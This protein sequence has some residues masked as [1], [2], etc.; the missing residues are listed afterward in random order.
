MSETKTIPCHE[1]TVLE[2]VAYYAAN[3]LQAQGYET[4]VQVMSPSMSVLIVKKDR[5][6]FKNLL[7]LGVETRA[8]LTLVNPVTI[9]AVYDSEWTNK[10][11]ALAVGWICC[12][13]PFIT[14][15]VGAVAQSELPNK[16]TT[17]I[18]A[19]ISQT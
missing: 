16:I 1:N 5:D 7:G 2:N 3:Y 13:I 19:G 6:G 14:G 17:S 9:S 8:T 15:L 11:I 4:G 12:L 18:D 10:I